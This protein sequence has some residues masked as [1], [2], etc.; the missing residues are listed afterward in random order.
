MKELLSCFKNLLKSVRRWRA[1]TPAKIEDEKLIHE[2][3]T[4]PW[5]HANSRSS[6]WICP[7]KS[8]KNHEA[9]SCRLLG[10]AEAAEHAHAAVLLFACACDSGY[11]GF[12]THFFRQII[13]KSGVLILNN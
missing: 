11:S 6:C 13:P 9:D 12:Y 5:L 8:P 4:A 2:F 3:E 10:A 1:M 7:R